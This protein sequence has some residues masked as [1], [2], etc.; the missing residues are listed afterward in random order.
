[1]NIWGGQ[2]DKTGRAKCHRRGLLSPS[3]CGES[4]LQHSRGSAGHTDVCS[5]FI[6]SSSHR[7]WSLEMK[8]SPEAHVK[9]LVPSRWHY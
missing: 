3:V 8:C 9:G 5:I 4:E 2:G 1:M 7:H 6:S